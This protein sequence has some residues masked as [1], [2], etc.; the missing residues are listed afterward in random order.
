MAEA[1]SL[2]EQNKKLSSELSALNEQLRKEQDRSSLVE[3]Q[4]NNLEVHIKDLEYRLEEAEVNAAKNSRKVAQKLEQRVSDLEQL[5]E[6]EQRRTE[7]SA[8]LVKKQEKRIKELLSQADEEQKVKLQ[9]QDSFDQLQQ[10]MKA[11]KRQ[12]EDTV[13]V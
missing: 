2:Q 6:A 11:F 7:E 5:V 3:K 4:R 12:V 13:S 8:K 10:K 1:T 9:L